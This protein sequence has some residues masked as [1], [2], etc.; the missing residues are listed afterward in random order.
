M[1]KEEAG[2]S[3]REQILALQQQMLTEQGTVAKE[4][5]E[6]IAGEDVAKVL[7]GLTKLRDRAIP[8]QALDQQI[9]QAIAVLAQ[10]GQT[11]AQ[12]FQQFQQQQR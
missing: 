3:A 9:G 2:K 12:L 4:L 1:A 10:L 11:G 8:G 5:V 7:D 6:Y